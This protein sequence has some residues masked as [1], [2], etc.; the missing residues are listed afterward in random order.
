MGFMDSLT[1]WWHNRT[2]KTDEVTQEPGEVDSE[3]ASAE[4]VRSGNDG[5]EQHHVEELRESTEERESD[6]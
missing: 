6:G 5:F 1:R 4:T 3:P 2:A